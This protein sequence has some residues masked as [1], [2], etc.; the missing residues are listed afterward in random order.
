MEP[1]MATE[2]EKPLIVICYAHAEKPA[3]AR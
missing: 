1:L 2:P 3:E